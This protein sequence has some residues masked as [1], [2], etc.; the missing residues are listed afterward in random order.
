MAD[1]FWRAVTKAAFVARREAW[2]HCRAEF[3]DPEAQ[4]LLGLYCRQKLEGH[5][6]GVAERFGLESEPVQAPGQ[7]WYHTE[8]RSGPVVLTA[9]TVPT[10]CAMVAPADYRK[11]LAE[12]AEQH[13]FTLGQTPPVNHAYYVLLL[14]SRYNGVTPDDLRKNGHLPGSVY[15]AWPAGDCQDYVHY[16]NLMA[17]YPAIAKEFVPEEWDE[18]A[19]LRYISRSRKS[20]VG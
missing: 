17:L 15:A 11:G 4:D 10:P 16:V 2:D 1:P 5:L 13:L 3:A 8:V 18:E 20:D 19:V 9:A 6:R 14:H 7:R 12:G